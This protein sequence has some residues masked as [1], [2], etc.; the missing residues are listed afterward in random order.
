MCRTLQVPLL[1]SPSL[2][3]GAF[4]SPKE[5]EQTSSG[6]GFLV[7]NIERTD[8]HMIAALCPQSTA[9]SSEPAPALIT[10]IQQSWKA[11]YQGIFCPGTLFLASCLIT[12]PL[13][14][15]KGFTAVTFR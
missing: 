15:W 6:Y 5:Q 4:L 8:S 9:L 7:L 1:A 3:V 13:L 10:D 2:P 11:G 14:T 12:V